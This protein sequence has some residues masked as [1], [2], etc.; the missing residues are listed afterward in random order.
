MNGHAM[1]LNKLSPIAGVFL[2]TLLSACGGGDEDAPPP[3]A[4]VVAPPAIVVSRPTLSNAIALVPAEFTGGTCSG[5]T[6]ALTASWDYGDGTFGSSKFHT[7]TSEGSRSVEVTCTDTKGVSAKSAATI[8]VGS[9][10]LAGFLGKKWSTYANINAGAADLPNPRIY[11][12]AGIASSGAIYGVW[13]QS[14]SNTQND[15]VYTGTNVAAGSFNI[16][17]ANWT[18]SSSPIQTGTT[19]NR[20]TFDGKYVLNGVGAK[21]EAMDMAV[22]PGGKAMAAWR[23]VTTGTPSVPATLWYATKDGSGPWSTPQRVYIVPGAPT[24][25]PV[26]V[27]DASIKVVVNDAGDGAIAYCTGTTPTASVVVYSNASRSTGAPVV[28][29]TQCDAIV[30]YGPDIQ[31]HRSFDIAIDDTSPQVRAVGL[32]ASTGGNSMVAYRTTP[33][34]SLTTRISGD[35]SPTN[36]PKSIAYSLAPNGD[37][38]GVAWDQAS[39]ADPLKTSIYASMWKADLTSAAAGIWSARSE[40][41]TVQHA[42]FMYPLIAVNYKGEAFLTAE[43]EAIPGGAGINTWVSNYDPTKVVA[44]VAGSPGTPAVT[45][46]RTP[47]KTTNVAEGDLTYSATDIAIDKWGTGLMTRSAFGTYSQAGTFSKVGTWSGFTQITTKINPAISTTIP[48]PETYED[49]YRRFHF[50]S[51]RA[52]E[53]GRAIL[54]T[55]LNTSPAANAQTSGYMLLK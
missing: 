52:L 10:A 4:A 25:V 45:G 6:T 50:Q 21:T 2:A 54:V 17:A 48:S 41:T 39:T 23:T 32:A 3:A 35:L 19:S 53:D 49:G 44:A 8:V 43:R 29:S 51:L 40:I 24:P 12:V 14:Y 42:G 31:R 27:I 16:T 34:L 20:P 36:L 26:P 11:P 37:F 38:A 15:D 28:I 7:Y 46:W 33:D 30:G 5:G 18:P 47:V 22:S 55:S 9:E 13:L 1:Q